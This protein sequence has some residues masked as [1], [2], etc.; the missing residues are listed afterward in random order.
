[1]FLGF[2]ARLTKELTALA[3]SATEVAVIA[4]QERLH[5]SFIGGSIL[6]SLSTFQSMWISKGEYDKLG[7]YIVHRK[8][9]S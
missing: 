7:P 6:A 9:F 2:A 3:P 5:S 1:M 4:P 8:C